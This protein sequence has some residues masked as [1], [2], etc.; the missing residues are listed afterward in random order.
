MPGIDQI[1]GGAPSRPKAGHMN[2]SNYLYWYIGIAS[3]I[4]ILPFGVYLL[5]RTLARWLL[6]RT[7]MVPHPYLEILVLVGLWLGFGL[8]LILVVPDGGHSEMAGMAE[9]M[10]WAAA[11]GPGI[12]GMMTA[13]LYC[14]IMRCRSWKQDPSR[15]T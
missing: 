1:R 8:F 10:A 5:L 7:P 6:G 4:S 15:T 2:D 13:G 9:A 11:I 12:G 3:L 14:L